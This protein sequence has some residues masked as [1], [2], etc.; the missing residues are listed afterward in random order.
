MGPRA[1]EDGRDRLQSGPKKL[2]G[3]MA[4]FITLIVVMVSWVG[5][6]AKTCQAVHAR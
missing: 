3:V 6:Y 2:I 5:T 1:G 4:M